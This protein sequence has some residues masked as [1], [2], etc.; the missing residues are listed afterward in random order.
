VG[1][2]AHLGKA[3]QDLGDRFVHTYLC[4]SGLAA[5]PALGA[6]EAFAELRRAMTLWRKRPPG[7]EDDLERGLGRARARLASSAAAGPAAGQEGNR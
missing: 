2:A 4:Q 7:W 1:L 3:G 6:Y 5:L